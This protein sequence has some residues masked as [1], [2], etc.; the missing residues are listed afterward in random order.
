MTPAH[1][2]QAP[3]V[4][5]LPKRLAELLEMDAELEG[6]VKLS[7]CALGPWIS[8]SRLPFFPE[9]TDHGPE[10]ISKRS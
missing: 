6:A 5:R 8:G 7:L 4:I 10:H 1:E 9:Y 2:G 3:P